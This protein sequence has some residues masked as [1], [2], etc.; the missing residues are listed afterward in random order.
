VSAET[1]SDQVESIKTGKTIEGKD[2]EDQYPREE[3]D[4]WIFDEDDEENEG[5]AKN[6]KNF[7]E[8]AEWLSALQ[9]SGVPVTTSASSAASSVKT[10]RVQQSQAEGQEAS[11]NPNSLTS[12]GQL[13]QAQSH[14]PAAQAQQQVSSNTA[15]KS[16]RLKKKG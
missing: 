8:A 11:T 12:Y 16:T 3:K 2:Y 13:R 1:G 10:A 4:F 15:P 5:L 6:I 14:F 7:F 9:E